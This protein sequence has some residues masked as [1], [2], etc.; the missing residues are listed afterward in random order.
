[1]EPSE[2]R[3]I[4]TNSAFTDELNKISVD[5]ELPHIGCEYNCGGVY[6]I[7]KFFYEQK[8]NWSERKDELPRNLFNHSIQFFDTGITKLQTYLKR[9][10]TNKPPIQS[11]KTEF[12][13]LVLSNIK[14]NNDV[15]ISN[16]PEVDFLIS[17]NSKYPNSLHAAYGFITNKNPNIGTKDGLQGTLLAYEFQNKESSYIFNRRE[18]EKKSIGQIRNR[19]SGL[20]NEY[21][22][23]LTAHIKKI[24][25]DYEE[26]KTK[27]DAF[28]QRS[29]ESLTQWMI[30]HKGEFELFYKDS[31]EK[32]A[33]LE[34][35]YAELLKL[36]EPIKYWKERARELRT[37]GNWILVAIIGCSILLAV[38]TVK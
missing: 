18:S 31:G 37:T 38:E 2:V 16:A 8:V 29:E 10:K 32:V 5:I 34:N 6:N 1:M 14:P 23:E 21:D 33:A 17:V 3:K 35:Q 36:Q 26:Y 19:I 28:E 13:R 24:T 25:K 27:L 11:V 15:F 22:N 9:I 30:T 4:I 12:D 20:A 7:Y